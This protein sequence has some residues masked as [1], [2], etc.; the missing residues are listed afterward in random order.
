MR[1][2]ILRLLGLISAW[3]VLDAA[4]G[5]LKTLYL[6][7]QVPKDLWKLSLTP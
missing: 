5:C 3:W 1:E 2:H 6:N 7:L 4:L